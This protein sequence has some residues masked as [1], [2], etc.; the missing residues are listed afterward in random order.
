MILG[1]VKQKLDEIKSLIQDNFQ[2]YDL[3]QIQNLLLKLEQEIKFCVKIDDSLLKFF[4]YNFRTISELKKFSKLKLVHIVKKSKRIDI[5]KELATISISKNL[6]I[7]GL[8]KLSGKSEILTQKPTKTARR[9]TPTKTQKLKI[10]DQTA[11]WLSLTTEKL[12]NEINDLT[13][14]PD[15]TALKQAASSI[16]KPNEKR[17][18]SRV[19]IINAIIDRTSEEKAIAH[20]GRQF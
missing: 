20:L 6:N 11:R 1:S 15:A 4:K 18:R 14:Y 7:D 9:K 12:K 2:K 16:L 17:M 10:K 8:K 19:K 5:E 13:R 3:K